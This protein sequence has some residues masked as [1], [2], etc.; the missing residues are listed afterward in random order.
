MKKTTK[1]VEF[2]N[3]YDKDSPNLEERELWLRAK[4]ALQCILLRKNKGMSQTDVANKMGITFQQVAKFEG[5]NNTPT[6]LFL[7]KYA[8][9]LDTNFDVILNGVDISEFIKS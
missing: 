1:Q 8:M 3:K 7:V 4:I 6:L 5:M 2:L 9:A